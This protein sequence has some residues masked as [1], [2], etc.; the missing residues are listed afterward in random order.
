MSNN[1][2][3]IIAHHLNHVFC[4]QYPMRT[5]STWAFLHWF[6]DFFLW[7]LSFVLH[8]I[9]IAETSVTCFPKICRYVGGAMCVRIWLHLGN[10]SLGF[11]RLE[12]QRIHNSSNRS[13]I[14]S[15][16][17]D[18][19][20][21]I[22]QEGRCYS[23][24]INSSI[25]LQCTMIA[26]IQGAVMDHWVMIC[27]SELQMNGEMTSVCLLVSYNGHPEF[28]DSLLLFICFFF[29]FVFSIFS[30]YNNCVG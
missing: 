2:Q 9:N 19:Y 5:P 8:F 6:A 17:L 10:S 12:G 16:L 27:P 1:D 18:P 3:N 22:R 26:C 25:F 13:Q 7:S 24:Y 15:L 29:V 30:C 11:L 23:S 20:L 21:E 14:S 4:F 28:P